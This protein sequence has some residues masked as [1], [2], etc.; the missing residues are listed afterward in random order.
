VVIRYEPRE[1]VMVEVDRAEGDKALVADRPFTYELV[2]S[3]L[4]PG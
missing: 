4:L 1:G 3:A 2:P